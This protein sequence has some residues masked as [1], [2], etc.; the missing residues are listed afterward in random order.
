MNFENG[1]YRSWQKAWPCFV[2]YLFLLVKV[3]LVTTIF[4]AHVF[5]GVF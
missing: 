5:S 2:I 1:V 3:A 4:E